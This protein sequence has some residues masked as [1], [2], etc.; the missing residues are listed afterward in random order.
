MQF[1][2]DRTITIAAHLEGHCL[3]VL[4]PLHVAL[5]RSGYG[6]AQAAPDRGARETDRLAERSQ[7]SLG[8]R[9]LLH[10]LTQ[11]GHEQLFLLA[12][13]LQLSSASFCKSFFKKS[14]SI[15]SC[16]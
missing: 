1:F 9:S 12:R 2:S 15:V 4:T 7:G 6:R 11:Q 14:F 3:D 5:S 8:G 13:S 10:F 16:P